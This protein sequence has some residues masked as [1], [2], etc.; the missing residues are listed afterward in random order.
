MS[1]SSTV[2]S[3]RLLQN[4]RAACLMAMGLVFLCGGVVGAL[5]FDLTAH[6]SA[7]KTPFWTDQKRKFER[8]LQ[9]RQR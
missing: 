4:P 3:P 9:E 2:A 1:L 6:K 5:L 7:Q 8:L